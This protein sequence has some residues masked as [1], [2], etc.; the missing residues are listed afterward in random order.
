MK[1]SASKPRILPLREP[2]FGLVWILLLICM[3]LPMAGKGGTFNM[4][5]TDIPLIGYGLILLIFGIP[6]GFPI[7]C[8]TLIYALLNPLLLFLSPTPF[9]F[10]ILMSDILFIASPIT[11]QW[12]SSSTGKTDKLWLV[13]AS[14]NLICVVA[15]LVTVLTTPIVGQ[16]DPNNY[17][18]QLLPGF[19]IWAGAQ[20]I[21]TV[22][23]ALKL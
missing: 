5:G 11:L 18:I 9:I 17:D 16:I 6:L 8:I 22:A 4:N 15:F 3:F 20:I 12:S 19:F 21:L 23:S 13:Y 7:T 2:L 10:Y 14:L 1:E